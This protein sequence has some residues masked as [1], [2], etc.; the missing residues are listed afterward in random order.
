MHSD[1]DDLLQQALNALERGE[2]VDRVI[3]RLPEGA[4]GLESLVRLAATVRDLDHPTPSSE[5]TLSFERKTR[6]VIRQV[7]S[8]PDIEKKTRKWKFPSFE[9]AFKPAWSGVAM[10]FVL[11][12]TALAWLFLSVA[13]PGSARTAILKDVSGD[14]QALSNGSVWKSVT[15]GDAIT[16]GTHLM[17]AAGAQATLLY[18]DGSQT[19]IG[20]EAEV[21]L[22]KLA[23]SLGN[24][25]QVVFE[26]QRGET[27]NQVVPLRGIGS[28]FRVLTDAGEVSVKGTAFQVEVAESGFT[29]FAVDH[30]DVQV[31]SASSS[32]HLSSGQALAATTG[33]DLGEPSYQFSLKGILGSNH[34]NIWFVSGVPFTILPGTITDGVG[35]ESPVQVEG[36]ILPSGEWVADRVTSTVD[37]TPTSTFTGVV[38][39]NAG[40]LLQVGGWTLVYPNP[41]KIKDSL[42]VGEAVRVDFIVKEGGIWQAVRVTRLNQTKEEAGETRQHGE[43][44]TGKAPW[45]MFQ[46]DD[47]AIDGCEAGESSPYTFTSELWNS[48]K[49][50]N[51]T[52]K[53][54]ILTYQIVQGAEFV[55]HVVLE[56]VS[57]AQIL[58]GE[59]ISLS[60]RVTLNPDA[61]NLAPAG[62]E[63][64]VQVA[65]NGQRTRLTMALNK[66][67]DAQLATTPQGGDEVPTAEA[68]LTP[69]PTAT[70]T[71]DPEARDEALCTGVQPHPTGTQLAEKYGAPYREIMGWFC[72]GYG[73][74][75]IDM[76]YEISRSV[77][78]P[79]EQVFGLR[80]GGAGWGEIKQQL[81]PDQQHNNPSD[82]EDKGKTPPGQAGHP[83]KTKGPKH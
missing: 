16:A 81:L 36:R 38:E 23:G 2:P 34:G 7:G 21:Y 20:P 57:W 12:A 74:G 48:G 63:V 50:P 6:P 67:C 41:A 66:S 26:Q 31:S 77:P 28:E 45:L 32:V 44:L 78:M 15:E 43:G 75:E 19:R 27:D 3:S 70:P 13:I 40:G 62:T 5:F 65:I 46:P 30:G 11:T 73:F 60:A 17:T 56:P 9:W 22:S 37:D 42:R 39:A 51:Q 14:V 58:P 10:A 59:K 64:Q 72:Q 76:A 82:S 71:P 24:S 80:A 68:T 47:M 69:S 33:E 53:D 8:G 18:M 25:I 83:E 1:E 61:W 49:S 35:V 52:G 54:I 4:T 29:R 79:V 55:S